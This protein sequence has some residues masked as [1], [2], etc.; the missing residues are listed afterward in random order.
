MRISAVAQDKQEKKLWNRGWYRVTHFRF[1]SNSD[2]SND[3]C[4]LSRQN[5][6]FCSGRGGD[7]RVAIKNL[8]FTRLITFFSLQSCNLG[9]VSRWRHAIFWQTNFHVKFFTQTDSQWKL[10]AARHSQTAPKATAELAFEIS[11]AI[12]LAQ[13]G[14]FCCLCIELHILHSLPAVLT[15]LL[16]NYDSG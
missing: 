11:I 5:E 10:T 16:A 12:N 15:Y 3:L 6:R 1:L 9:P 13:I 8:P 2:G 4:R 7:C 14:F